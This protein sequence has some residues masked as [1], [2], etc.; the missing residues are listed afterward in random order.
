MVTVSSERDEYDGKIVRIEGDCSFHQHFALC[1]TR[2]ML[3]K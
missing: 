3:T 2:P 1:L